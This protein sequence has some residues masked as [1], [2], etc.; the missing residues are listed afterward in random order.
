M[1]I[2]FLWSF[3]LNAFL[4]YFELKNDPGWEAKLFQTGFFFFFLKKKN[5]LC[6]VSSRENEKTWR[7]QN[8]PKSSKEL[9]KCENIKEPLSL[10]KKFDKNKKSWMIVI[11]NAWRN[12]KEEKQKSRLCLIAKARAFPL[13]PLQRELKGNLLIIETNWKQK[14]FIS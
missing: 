11:L 13:Q 10:R 6:Y 8:L 4:W 3:K 2:K 5:I 12:H 7:Q 14:A 9:K 1:F